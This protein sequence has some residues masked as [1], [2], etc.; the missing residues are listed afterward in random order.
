MKV[1][2]ERKKFLKVWQIAEKAASSKTP[3]E[4]ISGILVKANESGNVILEATDMK[5]SIKCFADG[6]EVLE[7]GTA[8][9]SVKIFGNLL[10]KTTAENVT[11]D[12]NSER[13]M[14]IYGKSKTRF[15]I[16]NV[17]GFPHLPDSATSE[18]VCEIM[19]VDFVRLVIE[20]SSASSQPQ[21][22][23]RYMG[24]CL[25]RTT[26][27]KIEAVSTDGKRLAL[28]KIIC[29]VTK[30]QD[31]LLHAPALKEFG[32]MLSSVDEEETIKISCDTSTAFFVLPD[33]EYSIRLVDSNFPNY[34]R[35]LNK[36]TRTTLKIAR[37][38]L[39]EVIERVD[40]IA[41]TTPAHI[42]AFELQPEG[43]LI[44]TTRAP[45]AGTAQE[46]LEAEIKGEHMQ[47]GFNVGYFQDGLKALGSCDVVIEFSD[48]E[49]QCR[50]KRSE[51]DDF[52][53]MLMPAR[54]TEQDL[55]ADTELIS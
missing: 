23:P 37:D 24:T 31:L 48:K 2:L 21:E 15:A 11:L 17:D 12:V 26:E 32:K 20:G 41:R 42:M 3:Q 14:L 10:K 36:D 19:C 51:N 1:K 8:V 13:G 5:S 6:V 46:F 43:E 22:F 9:L 16:F 39:L 35:I 52:L 40:V 45:D 18:P 47:V 33:F 54:L 34:E 53:Y 38:E 30:N 44:I 7:P 55:I 28:A 4:S 29:N 50:I 49:G 25:F 27:N